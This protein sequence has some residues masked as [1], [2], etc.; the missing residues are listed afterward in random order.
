MIVMNRIT[1]GGANRST[2]AHMAKDRKGALAPVFATKTK[3]IRAKAG[4]AANPAPVHTGQ[5]VAR[6]KVAARI[7]TEAGRVT[8]ITPA[9]VIAAMEPMDRT[10]TRAAVASDRTG[11]AATDK[12][13]AGMGRVP[14]ATDRVAVAVSEAEATVTTARAR[15]AGAVLVRVRAVTREIT[16]TRRTTRPEEC[17]VPRVAAAALTTIEVAMV[18]ARNAAMSMRAINL[19]QVENAAGGI[20]PLMQ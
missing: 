8:A 6:M 18:A 14:V 13:R 17:T 1:V 7:M 2:V 20:A 5:E 3:D 19:A 11:V 9:I 15:V 4:G 12:A 10:I 16:T